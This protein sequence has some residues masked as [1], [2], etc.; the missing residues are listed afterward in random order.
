MVLHVEMAK[1]CLFKGPHS[2]KNQKLRDMFKVY[3]KGN[4]K[5]KMGLQNNHPAKFKV[6]RNGV[7][8]IPNSVHGV[9]SHLKFLKI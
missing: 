1:T 4:E 5:E 3:V 9:Q 2:M 6:A 7:Q 8:Q